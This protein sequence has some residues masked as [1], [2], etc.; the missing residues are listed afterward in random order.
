MEA[1]G[2][3]I[4]FG[5]K[6]TGVSA[7]LKFIHRLLAWGVL[8]FSNR[9]VFVLPTHPVVFRSNTPE[10]PDSPGKFRRISDFTAFF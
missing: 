8:G 5:K 1:G 4:Y 3:G 6:L 9:W 7:Q 2:G 10:N